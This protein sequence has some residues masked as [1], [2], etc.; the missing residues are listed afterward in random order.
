[1]P[2]RQAEQR[3]ALRKHQNGEHSPARIAGSGLDLDAG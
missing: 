1:M 2:A 3:Y